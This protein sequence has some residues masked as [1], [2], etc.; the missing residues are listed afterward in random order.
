MRLRAGKVVGRVVLTPANCH[1]RDARRAE[2]GSIS[3]RCVSDAGSRAHARM[4]AKNGDTMDANEL[5]AMQAPIK[6]R[7]KSDPQAAVVTLKAKGTLDDSQYRLQGRD[8]PRAATPPACI[9]RPA[10][11]GSNCARATCCWKRWSPAPASRSRRWRP[12]STSRS[13]RAR[14]RRKAISISAA[15]SASPR[16]RRSDFREIR[17]RF[18][19]DTDAPQDKLDQLL[20]LTERYCVVYQT[21]KAGP[22]VE[23]KMARVDCRLA[24]GLIPCH[25]L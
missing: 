23:V 9:R 11:R 7:Y 16:M 1:H 25:P 24:A 4:T 6:E 5:R 22:P 15:R 10:V 20:K 18:D 12:R 17:L 21:I 14:C 19:L 8:R 2:P 3:D 13:S